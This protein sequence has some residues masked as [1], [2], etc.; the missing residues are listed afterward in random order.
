MTRRLRGRRIPIKR[1]ACKD[2]SIVSLDGNGAAGLAP[3]STAGVVGGQVAA[4]PGVA[5][6]TRTSSAFPTPKAGALGAEEDASGSVS[7][8]LAPFVIGTAA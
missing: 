5:G 7:P 2:G 1:Q 4:V 6:A 3:V 8:V